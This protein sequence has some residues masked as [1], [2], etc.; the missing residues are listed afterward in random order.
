MGSEKIE[1]IE[2]FIKKETKKDLSESSDDTPLVRKKVRKK[3]L[4]DE[5]SAKKKKTE[6]KIKPIKVQKLKTDGNYVIE[7]KTDSDEA[8][9]GWKKGSISGKSENQ[10][11]VKESIEPMEIDESITKSENENSA[12]RQTK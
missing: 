1:E 10:K 3:R 5:N 8:P 11:K 4:S 12:K 9:L 7:N 6:E 2:N